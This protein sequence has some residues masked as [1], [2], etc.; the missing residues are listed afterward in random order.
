MAAGAWTFYNK[1]KKK[2]GNGSISLAGTVFRMSLHTSA[3]NAATAT[4]STYSQL[5]GS[6]ATGNGY[7]ASGQAL[8]GEVWTVGASAGQYKWDCTDPIWTATG[9]T[10]PNIKYGVIWLSAAST[11]GRHVVCYSQLT[12]AQFT[13]STSSTMTVTMNASGIATLT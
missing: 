6:V 12:T 10:I 5:T 9:G 2:I 11:N 1:A 3:S 7:A 4:L 13:L 8:T